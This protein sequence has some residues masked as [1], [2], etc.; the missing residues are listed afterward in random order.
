[1]P[2]VALV[3]LV[4][5]A[6]VA[7]GWRA[8]L[9]YKRTGDT[10]LRRPSGNPVEFVG[11]IG[12]IG[13]LVALAL[14]PLLDLVGK[15]EQIAV[16]TSGILQGLGIVLFAVGLVLTVVAQLHM[17]RS[18]RVG[19]DPTETT[20]PVT[21]G[22]FRRVRNPIFTSMV[23]AGFGV[24]LMVP[25]VIAI[26]GVVSLLLGLEVQ[27]RFVEEPYLRRVHGEAYDAYTRRAGRFLP[28]I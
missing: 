26:A 14:A 24:A 19:V 11:G 10:G 7:F 22:I 18:W 5:F 17:G 28:R 13:G 8:W 12:F 20:D 4:A 23:L 6:L 15:V 1:M 9:Q 3:G 2:V 21:E 25:N 27:V 16:L